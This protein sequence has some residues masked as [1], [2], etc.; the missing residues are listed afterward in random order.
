MAN[1][2]EPYDKPL[3]DLCAALLGKPIYPS[4]RYLTR[5][6]RTIENNQTPIYDDIMS[7]ASP[8]IK[9][10]SSASP[11]SSSSA[12]SEFS[13]APGVL[14]K[15]EYTNIVKTKRQAFVHSNFGNVL[16]EF[17][18]LLREDATNSKPCHREI[19]FI[20]PEHFDI[21][22]T[23]RTLCEY[24]GDCDYKAIPEGRKDSYSNKIVL[25]IT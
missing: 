13:P 11:S 20:I 17:F 15:K 21:E 9:L 22:K 18:N 19:T 23:E 4:T 12:S 3:P 1:G 8:S 7:S 10:A 14:T 25:T 5:R 16:T 24:F 6:Q 2:K